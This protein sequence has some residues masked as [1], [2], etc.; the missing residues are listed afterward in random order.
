VGKNAAKQ[1]CSYAIILGLYFVPYT[2]LKI[3]CL[4]LTIVINVTSGVFMAVT[5]KITV[6]WDR[7]LK[8]ET[9]VSS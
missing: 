8:M 1:A 5:T 2:V 9:T 7:I 4:L 6:F 3:L